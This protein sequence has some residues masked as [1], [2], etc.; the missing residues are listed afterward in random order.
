MDTPAE[1]GKRQPNAVLHRLLDELG[2]S[3]RTLAQR[4]NRA[5]GAGT[6]AETAPY[7]WRDTGRIPRPP[8]PTLVA[9]LLSAELGRPVT[10]AEL[11][12]GMATESPY[13]V[14]AD[15][16]LDLPW[17]RRGTLKVIDDWVV[18]GL[19][20]RRQFLAISG[21]SLTAQATGYLSAPI[22]VH[23]EPLAPGDG[24]PLLEQLEHSIPLLQKLDDAGGGGMHLDYVGAHFRTVAL[25]I[26]QG[27]HAAKVENRLIAALATIGQLAGWM[28]FDAGKHGL[29]QRY[30]F[31]ALR[32]ARESNYRPMA[33]HIVADLAFQAATLEQPEDAVSLGETAAKIAV[34]T[35]VNVRAS[36]QTRLSYGYAISGDVPSFEQAYQSALDMVSDDQGAEQPDWMYFL[37]PNHLDVQAGYAL[38]H[39]GTLAIDAGDRTTGRKLLR[40]G[41][42]LLRTGAYQRPL[43]DPQQRRSLFEGAWLATAA[44]A[45]GK[46]EDACAIGMTA[47]ERMKTVRSARSVD[48]LQRLASRLRRASRNEYVRDFL[49]ILERALARQVVPSR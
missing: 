28:A 16:G 12:Q 46:F 8:V 5:F 3:P 43:D 48:V 41:E 9:S 47:T 10:V 15:T 31:T 30:F 25:L 19:L 24:G 36:V 13:V 11:W 22:S 26:R 33:A 14:T 35:P 44:A 29:A 42:A 21:A 49:P 34:G 40:R 7:H 18:S 2:W 37:T 38:A 39:A 32:A 4:V 1:R 20:D 6:I 23:Q 45:S 27:G 17:G